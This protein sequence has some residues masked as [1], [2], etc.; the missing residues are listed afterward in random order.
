MVSTTYEHPTNCATNQQ[1]TN[2]ILNQGLVL[3]T[4]T[5]LAV[6][7]GGGT[8]EEAA[9]QAAATASVTRR[10]S[11]LESYASAWGT[12]IYSVARGD[13][14][15]SA[16]A[17]TMARQLR[18]TKPQPREKMTACYLDSATPAMLDMIVASRD[19]DVF[20]SLL[21][22]ANIGG[23]NVHRGSCLGAILGLS[24]SLRVEHREGLYPHDK[25]GSDIK[26]FLDAVFQTEI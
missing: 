15:A 13:A 20:A 7:A 8:R 17:Q 26:E 25:I 3:P 4:I 11:V 21:V 5:A 18:L 2:T 14:D 24:S 12:A 9:R 23:E 6:A 19:R 10:S 1:L 22:N 16:A